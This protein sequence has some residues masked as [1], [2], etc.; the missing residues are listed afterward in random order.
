MIR[1][2]KRRTLKLDETESHGLLVA[3]MS[4]G[5]GEV[6]VEFKLKWVLQS[7]SAPAGWRRCRTC[8]LR[9]RKS[10]KPGACPLDLVSGDRARVERA[11]KFVVG[12]KGPEV[13][14]AVTD[15][16]LGEEGEDLVRVLKEGQAKFDPCGP[17]RTDVEEMKSVEYCT[18]MT[19]RDCTLFLVVREGEV[20]RRGVG[21][22]DLKSA[23]MGKAA[24]W[25]GQEEA[26]VSE[27]WYMGRGLE[28]QEEGCHL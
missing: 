15:W 22:L 10:G 11:V 3:D 13:E 23:G 20:V 4:A 9:V 18:A 28:D 2:A 14:A 25:K 6:G 26:L 21:D 27:G 12:Q 5:A 1:P 7:G 19:L 8:A 17:G 24:Y 16:L